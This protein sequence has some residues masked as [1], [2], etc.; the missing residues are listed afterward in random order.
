MKLIKKSESINVDLG[1]KKIR[2]YIASDRSM[3][4]NHIIISGRFPEEINHYVYET[5]VRFMIYIL[6]GSGLIRS[7]TETLVVEDG[8]VVYFPPKSKFAIESKSLEYLA[9]E[10][11]AWYPEQAFIVDGKGTV[12]EETKI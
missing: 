2:K 6:N 8:D 12:L 1:N 7:D 11:P 4:M 10:T 3:E 9:A 5:K